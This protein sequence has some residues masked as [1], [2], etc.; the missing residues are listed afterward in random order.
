MC[1]LF[2]LGRAIITVNCMIEKMSEE[3]RRVYSFLEQ[4]LTNVEKDL[5]VLKKEHSQSREGD[6][7][8]QYQLEYK[9]ILERMISKIKLNMFQSE[10]SQTPETAFLASVVSE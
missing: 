2:L 4:T 5:H 9:A 6:L 3:S 10:S 7:E 8:Y 1:G